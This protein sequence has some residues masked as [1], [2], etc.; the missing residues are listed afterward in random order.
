MDEDGD[1]EYIVGIEIQVLNAIVLEHSLKEL[2]GGKCQSTLHELG[3]HRDFVRV[4]LHGV[5]I[6]GGGAP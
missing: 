1:V 5:L 4:L 3:E 6:A 2:D